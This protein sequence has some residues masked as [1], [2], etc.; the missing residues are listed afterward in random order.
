MS[1]RL[2]ARVGVLWI[3][4]VLLAGQTSLSQEHAA[5]VDAPIA[6]HAQLRVQ[7]GISSINSVAISPD[8]RRVLN[9]RLPDVTGMD[10][11]TLPPI[12][13][14]AGDYNP[15]R[16]SSWSASPTTAAV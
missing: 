3:G 10:T 6:H 13:A 7:T 12:L 8:G 11:V 2:A 4:A 14:A 1:S 9:Q 15:P 5:D 16:T